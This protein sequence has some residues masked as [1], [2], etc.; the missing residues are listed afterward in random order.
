LRAWSCLYWPR[1]SGAM[2]EALL[3]DPDAGVRAQAEQAA[4][5]FTPA[6][7]DYSVA[8]EPRVVFEIRVATADEQWRRSMLENGCVSRTVV[9]HVLASQPADDGQR[10]QRFGDLCAFAGNPTVPPDYLP[11][12]LA[13]GCLGAMPARQ[14]LTPEPVGALATHP[15]QGVR[16][17]LVVNPLLSEEERLAI[18]VDYSQDSDQHLPM[19]G[20]WRLHRCWQGPGSNAQTSAGNS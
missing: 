19:G 6:D 2:R 7:F 1:M 12:F 8:T 16:K 10:R 15:D 18:K 17:L 4:R 13:Q 3:A 5:P 9:D 14:D 20:A 11:R